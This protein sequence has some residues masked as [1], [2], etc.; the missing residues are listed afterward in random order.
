MWVAATKMH[1]KA[2]THICNY[3]QKYY[4][5]QA[6]CKIHEKTVC[7]NQLHIFICVFKKLESDAKKAQLNLEWKMKCTV[8]NEE[9]ERNIHPM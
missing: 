2:I 7:T 4:V 8:L 1:I 6:I 9:R 3:V 5:K